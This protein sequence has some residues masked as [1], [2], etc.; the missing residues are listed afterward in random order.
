MLQDFRYA[1]RTI[2]QAPGFSVVVTLTIARVRLRLGG[3]RS[4]RADQL[5]GRP[6]PAGTRRPGRNRGAAA[7]PDPAR[8]RAKP[9]LDGDRHRL[10]RSRRAG[11]SA[12]CS[13]RS[14]SESV[15]VIRACTPPSRCCFSSWRCWRARCR[16]CA[17]RAPTRS[18]PCAWTNN[19][20][21]AGAHPTI[22]Q[23]IF[24]FRDSMSAPAAS[25]IGVSNR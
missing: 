6:A 4:L 10:G 9:T 22:L 5:L 1:V 7:R 12:A 23:G 11:P 17:Q 16:R 21:R 25:A 15:D 19:Y 20:R 3:D 14:S 8:P 2:R 13:R 18:T 24:D